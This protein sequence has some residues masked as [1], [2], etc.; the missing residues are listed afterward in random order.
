LAGEHPYL[1]FLMRRFDRGEFSVRGRLR[2]CFAFSFKRTTRTIVRDRANFDLQAQSVS[3]IIW[4]RFRE[5]AIN[6]VAVLKRFQKPL[7]GGDFP[8]MAS[9]GYAMRHPSS[10]IDSIRKIFFRREPN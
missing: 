4:R 5:E 9:A 2:L 3:I 8:A 7:A 10:E 6:D 1:A